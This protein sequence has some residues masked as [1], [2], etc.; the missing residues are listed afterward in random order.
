MSQHSNPCGCFIDFFNK[1][2]F[3]QLVYLF[4]IDTDLN[5]DV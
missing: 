3:F 5:E 4:E 2:E 1:L